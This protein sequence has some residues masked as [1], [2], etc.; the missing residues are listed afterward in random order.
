MRLNALVPYGCESP[1]CYPALGYVYEW[2]D[3]CMNDTLVLKLILF[4][5]FCICQMNTSISWGVF[6]IQIA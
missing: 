6:F 2:T 5:F 3:I 1:H 4:F